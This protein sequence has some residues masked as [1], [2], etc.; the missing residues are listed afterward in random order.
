LQKG[1]IAKL[2]AAIYVDDPATPPF[3][4]VGANSVIE[5]STHSW[6]ISGGH[7]SLA[8]DATIIAADTLDIAGDATLTVASGK[9]LTLNADG[10]LGAKFTGAGAVVADVTK[11]AGETY[12]WQVKSSGA[13]TA[14]IAIG[15][16]ANASTITTDTLRVTL[17][18]LGP[19]AVI[20]QGNAATNNLTINGTTAL[21]TVGVPPLSPP[22]AL[23]VI[24]IENEYTIFPLMVIL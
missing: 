3:L 8:D 5:I 23:V 6:K 12:G 24:E 20:T 14:T 10:T 15:A 9:K 22:H 1:A 7:V 18:A 4:M 19:G 21:S 11:I 13:G 17:T 16:A 2:A